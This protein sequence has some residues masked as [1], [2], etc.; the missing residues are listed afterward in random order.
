MA[1]YRR[2]LG[3]RGAVDGNHD[4]EWVNQGQGGGYMHHGANMAC[5]GHI[6]PL[7]LISFS[8]YNYRRKVISAMHHIIIYR[9]QDRGMSHDRT[10]F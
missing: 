2:S 6:L 10:E 5:L 3:C 1:C 9:T 7:D 8:C 4:I